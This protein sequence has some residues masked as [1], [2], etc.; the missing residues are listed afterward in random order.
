MDYKKIGQFI[1]ELRENKKM[2]QDEL[3]DMIPI[4]R[5]AVSKWENGNSIPDPIV[6]I[7]LSEIFNVSINEILLGQKNEKSKPINSNTITLELYKK[8]S[9]NKKCIKFLIFSIVVM[10]IIFLSYY[11][12][13]SF[14]S[15]KIYSVSGF[16]E[17]FEI[18]DG[19]L[20]LTNKKYYFYI[21]NIV[22][23]T[24]SEIEKVE[25]YLQY[26]NDDLLL[27]DS[28]DSTYMLLSELKGYN[29]YEINKYVDEDYKTYMKIYSKD[30]SEL[31]ELN[32]TK[33]FVN[34]YIIP[35]PATASAIEQNE[36]NNENNEPLASENDILIEK[37]KSS[38]T[39]EEGQS[40][41]K[42]KYKD[43]II[44]IVY[45]E[46]NNILNVFNKRDNILIETWHYNIDLKVLG[47]NND[48]TSY[49]IALSEVQC[50][51]GN[52]SD[53]KTKN[54]EFWSIINASIN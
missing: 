29:E 52:C 2:T 1:K 32:Y 30:N 10:L 47:Y 34:D 48:E 28:Q 15:T 5:T 16:G 46:V 7:K 35:K 49:L 50:A 14:K 31:I 44:T 39:P 22:S 53:W 27:L 11:F 4:G 3:A 37:L 42:M 54:N 38:L 33:D 18:T 26:K 51:R 23:K 41:K 19:M 8:M 40:S 20:F 36:N 17:T 6:L 45:T 21:G 25:L 9:K 24:G 43:G 12:I 13:T